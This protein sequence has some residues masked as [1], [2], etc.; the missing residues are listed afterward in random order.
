[1]TK[2]NWTGSSIIQRSLHPHVH[3]H[4]EIG[5]SAVQGT[6]VSSVKKPS[7]LPLHPLFQDN[8]AAL[9]LDAFVHIGGIVHS[10]ERGLL[11]FP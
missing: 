9:C 7:P 3:S 1:M 8:S 4:N 6:G 11:R 2:M 5:C 10:G